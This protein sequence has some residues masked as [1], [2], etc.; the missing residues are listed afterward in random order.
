MMKKY[1]KSAYVPSEHIK[2][3]YNNVYEL[4]DDLIYRGEYS[5]HDQFAIIKS[6]EKQNPSALSCPSYLIQ[7]TAGSL[8]GVKLHEVLYIL[9]IIHFDNV[10]LIPESRFD[11]NEFYDEVIDSM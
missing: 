10:K 2:E 7:G 9:D 3:E 11:I 5:F 8:Y 4:A 6:L 1:I